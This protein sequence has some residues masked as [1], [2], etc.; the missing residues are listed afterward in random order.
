MNSFDKMY[1]LSYTNKAN[2][3]VQW[4]WFGKNNAV[5]EYV[6]LLF[7]INI[8]WITVYKQPMNPNQQFKNFVS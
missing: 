8:F 7:V 3:Q 5:S 1:T 2:I 4:L 6:P